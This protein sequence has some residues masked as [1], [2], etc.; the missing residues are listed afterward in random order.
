MA[1]AYNRFDAMHWYETMIHK[2][3]RAALAAREAAFAA[4]FDRMSYQDVLNYIA[5]RGRKLHRTPKAAEVIGSRLIMERY[6]DW[7]L[8]TYDAGMKGLAVG[9]S[10]LTKTDLYKEEWNRQ[11]QLYKAE[12]QEKRRKQEERQQC[13]LDKTARETGLVSVEHK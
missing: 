8:L 4:Q 5:V 9:P 1:G 11:Q 3:T 6:G 10:S 12:R 13:R 2:R 7:S